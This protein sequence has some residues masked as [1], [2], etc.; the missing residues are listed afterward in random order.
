MKIIYALFLALLFISQPTFSADTES[1]K[2]NDYTL[3]DERAK[4]APEFDDM[5]DLV[6]YLIQPFRGDEKLKARVIFMWI[7]THVQ[8]DAYKADN[9][10]KR[11]NHQKGFLKKNDPY[12]SRLGVCDDIATLFMK[13][14]SRAHLNS[15]K[16]VGYAGDNITPQTALQSLHSW[17]AVKIKGKWYLLDATWAMEGKYIFDQTYQK[18]RDYKKMLAERQKHPEKIDLG[19]RSVNEYWFLTPPEKMIKTHFP[20]SEKWQLLK[21]P[22]S[23]KKIWKENQKKNEKK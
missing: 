12:L 9:I 1:T 17:N 6:K 14:A 13:M 20:H 23:L 18:Q 22:V 19:N 16:I 21:K 3:A 11:N 2:P 7:V 5:P 10:S 8:Y 15:E 4:N